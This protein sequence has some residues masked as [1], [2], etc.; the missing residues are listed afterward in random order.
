MNR[1][2]E[3]TILLAIGC[4]A[5]FML[6]IETASAGQAIQESS[7]I[8]YHIYDMELLDNGTL[9][10]W[11]DDTTIQFLDPQPGVIFK[12]WRQR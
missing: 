10:Q 5:G 11:L 9:I 7:G 2:N 3:I 1:Y 4:I 8:G 12:E 6:F